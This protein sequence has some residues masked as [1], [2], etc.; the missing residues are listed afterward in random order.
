MDFDH[1]HW[2]FGDVVG[3]EAMNFITNTINQIMLCIIAVLLLTT[4]YYRYQYLNEAELRNGVESALVFQSQLIESNR[5]DYER[6][7]D[8]A[9]SKNATVRTEYVTKIKY[10]E[11]GLDE[12]SSC[13]DA[14]RFFDNYHY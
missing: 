4:L 10:I 3:V 6:N 7:M 2:L 14:L 8:E 13:A 1:H 9:K 12:N 11:R 5:V